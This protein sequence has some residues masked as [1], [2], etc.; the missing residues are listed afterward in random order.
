MTCFQDTAEALLGHNAESLRRLRDTD[1]TAFD[2]VFYRA[3]RTTYVFKNKVKLE[4]Y[5]D[6]NRVK[7]TV[8][9]IQPV[10]HRE[11]SRRLINSINRMAS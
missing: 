10:D 5:N 4:T 6:E 11:Y 2:D 1:E 8:M 7:T 9:E 3:K